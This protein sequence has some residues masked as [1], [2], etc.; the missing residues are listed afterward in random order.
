MNHFVHS[1]LGHFLMDQNDGE[2]NDLGG[3]EHEEE[4]EQEEEEDPPEEE[5]QE[6]DEVVVTLAG[7]TIDTEEDAE[8]KA[9]PTW[10]KELRKSNREQQKRIRELEAMTTQQEQQAQQ[11]PQLGKK[12]SMDDADIDYDADKFEAK[13]TA[14]HDQ[15]RA[16][17][18]QQQ[19]AQR[20]QQKAKDDWQKRLGQYGDAKAA[21]KVRD[22]DD[23]EESVKSTLNVTQQGILIQ[24]ADNPALVVYAL[25]RNPAKAKEL[26]AI[27]DHVKFAFAVAKLETQLKVQ[28][29]KTAPPPEKTITGTGR[30]SGAGDATL[31]RLRAD[32]E[33][34]GD[35]SK[36]N[37]YKRAQKQK[38]RS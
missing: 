30:I 19:E 18:Q 11:L 17:D 25:G 24:G 7:K 3:G 27:T 16:I 32:A 36:V 23:A 26:A 10:V 22:F 21:L 9:A 31:E 33:K 35:L 13:L 6:E 8:M 29:K 5:E 34:T 15:K 4:E 20:T 12:P 37:A 38:S 2:G 28:S 14:W 1:K